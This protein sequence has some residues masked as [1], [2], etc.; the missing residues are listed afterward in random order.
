M[1]PAM[2]Q[3]QQSYNATPLKSHPSMGAP[4]QTRRTSP[5]HPWM[6]DPEPNAPAR[7]P[8]HPQPEYWDHMNQA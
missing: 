6:P 8:I 5:E 7:P 3:P 1:Q 2:K 4:P